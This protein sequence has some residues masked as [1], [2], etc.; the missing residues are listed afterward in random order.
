MS[1]RTDLSNPAIGDA[2]RATFLAAGD[3]L[4]KIGVIKP[5]VSVP[6]TIN[7]LIYTSYLAD[8][9]KLTN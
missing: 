8:S 7:A 1:Q 5:E 3:I 2:H 4:Q 9:Q 6:D